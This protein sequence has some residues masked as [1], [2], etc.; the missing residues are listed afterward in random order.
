MGKLSHRDDTTCSRTPSWKVE[1]VRS[2]S[3]TP[4][5]TLNPCFS[6]TPFVDEDPVFSLPWIIWMPSNLLQSSL[7]LLAVVHSA[8]LI[9]LAVYVAVSLNHLI[10]TKSH[11]CMHTC[12]CTHAHIHTQYE[13]LQLSYSVRA[14]HQIQ[15][16][17]ASWVMIEWGTT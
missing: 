14:F 3:L 11:S 15:N 1:G 8:F 16:L 13:L 6:L 12:K 7:I 17:K 10:F 9:V 2:N 4:E 5:Y